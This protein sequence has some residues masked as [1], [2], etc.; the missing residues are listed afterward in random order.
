MGRRIKTERKIYMDKFYLIKSAIIG[1][2]VGDALGVPVEFSSRE[3]MDAKPVEKMEG[4]GTYPYPAGTWSDD[5]SM[6]LA[7]LDSLKDGIDF[8][9]MMKKFCEWYKCAKY[10]ASDVVFDIGNATRDSLVDYL[11]NA[12]PAVK[13]GRE[14][15]W[16]NGNGSLMRIMPMVL[17]L[18]FS[19]EKEISTED[20]ID[21]IEKC[22]CLTHAH[23]RSV[24][25]CGIYAF[26]VWE[27]LLEKSKKAIIRGL[28][29]AEEHYK[30]H[31]EFR[32]YIRIF[33]ENFKDTT[34]KEISGSGY[35]VHC[36]EA[37]IWCLLNTDSYK[38]CVLSAVNLGEDTDTTASVAGGLAGLLYG[39][40]EI[41]EDWRNTLIRRKY[42][43]ELCEN[44]AECW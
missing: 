15:S 10:T 23:S 35:V 2:A 26:V 4:F 1:F 13:C 25:G 24:I 36:L 30:N 9:D 31:P 32:H 16:N 3:K 40:N 43:E 39:Y 14:N 37:A 12:I 19:G 11:Q 18:F 42:I 41:P 27:L 7:T 33:D 21:Y 5:T 28:R 17:Y 6:T 20:K 29:K 8:E 22:S 34:R 38:D 44:A